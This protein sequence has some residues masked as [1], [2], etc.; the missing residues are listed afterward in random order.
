MPRIADRSG[1]RPVERH[2][3]ASAERC[4]APGGTDA[5][6]V[7]DLSEQALDR[8]ATADDRACWVGRLASGEPRARTVDAP[9]G[10]PEAARARVVRLAAATV[11]RPPTPTSGPSRRTRC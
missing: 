1:L 11:G 8:P 4:S 9:T 6:Y 10:S 2:L 7:D 3:F 5:A